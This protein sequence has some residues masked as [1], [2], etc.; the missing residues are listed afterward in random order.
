MTEV[1]I[2][3]LIRLGITASSGSFLFEKAVAVI[4]DGI[5]AIGVIFGWVNR[6]FL[7]A[8]DRRSAIYGQNSHGGSALP[9][10]RL[11]GLLWRHGSG[12]TLSEQLLRHFP[13]AS[14]ELRKR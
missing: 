3:Q 4:V 10:D 5:N 14:V 6:Q 12:V 13:L 8:L 2:K 9:M 1:S 11:Y 7:T